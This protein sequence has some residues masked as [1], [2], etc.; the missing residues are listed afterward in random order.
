MKLGFGTWGLGG[1]DYGSLSSNYATN[2]I[3]F[4]LKKKIIFF[5]TAPLY[6]NG[7]SERLLGKVIKKID[8]KNIIIATKGGMLPHVG[9]NLKQDFTILNLKKDLQNSLRRLNTSYIDYYLLHSPNIR[10]INIKEIFFFFKQ[11][12]KDKV[13]K[14]FGISLKSPNDI[15]LLKDF[16]TDLDVVEFNFNLFDQRAIDIQ[17]FSLLKKYKIISICRTPLCFGFLQTRDI[18]KNSLSST[19]HRKNFWSDEQFFRWNSSKKIFLSFAKSKRYSDFSQ[20][21]LHFCMSFNFDH[22]IPGMMKKKDIIS[23]IK[24]NSYSKINKDVLNSIY[25]KYKKSEEY[26]FVSKK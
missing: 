2:L 18:V 24:I 6:G 8:R 1:K 22:V 21:A 23:N 3:N 15:F 20:F 26:I 9:F 7:R 25:K 19:D 4:A 16:F 17:I 14:K 12:K 11:L 10:K 13:I 5:D